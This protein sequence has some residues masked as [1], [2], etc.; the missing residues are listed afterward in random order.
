MRLSS[1]SVV[2]YRSITTAH[3]IQMNNL[4]V[5]VGKNNEGKS[6]ILRALNLAMS[7]MQ[8]FAENPRILNMNLSAIKSR[9]S[10]ER[11]YP[12]SLQDRKPNGYSSVDFTFDLTESELQSIRS[13][14]G[15]RLNSSLPVRV[16]INGRGAKIDIPKRGTPAFANIEKKL[17]I[18]EFVCQKIDIKFIPAIRTEDDSL[19]VIT[20]LIENELSALESSPEYTAAISTI[21]DLQQRV[22][23][24]IASQ[25]VHP[26]R[27]FLP[28]VRDIQIRI[29]REQRRVALRRNI[30]VVVD[31]GTPTPIQL[32]G[33][34]IKSLTAIAMLNIANEPGIVSVIAIEEPES[35]LHPE[36]TR[37]L[38]QTISSLSSSHQV[39]ITTHSPL[40]VNRA[41]LRDNIIVNNGKATPVKRIKEIREVLGTHVCD[42]LINAEYILLVEGESD[43]VALDKLLPSM[44]DRIKRA[45]QNGTLVIDYI[46]GAGNLPYKLTF[47][48]SI[49]CNYYVLLDNDDAGRQAY[50]AATA[51]GLLSARNTT[52]TMCN[53]SPNAELEDCY[54]SVAYEQAILREF[55]VNIRAQEFSTNKKWSER[56]AN[57]FRSQ[58][59]LWNEAVEKHVKAVVATAI[60]DEHTQALNPHKRASID[61]LANALIGIMP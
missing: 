47:Y 38:F 25:I 23:D 13:L 35:H 54:Q 45:L 56:V 7:I 46:G 17:K 8:L 55:G 4:T 41:S 11:D 18:I 61:A 58:G 1:F 16:L 21:V 30:E 27:E 31:D 32:K 34:G 29:Q 24:R 26:L 43:K 60:I 52:F 51:Q 53:G 36:S 19:R 48:R 50:Q 59:K 42:N 39:I 9:Y 40:F 20:S 14:T 2:N 22:L 3:K 44:S 28:P 10:W 49:Q 33:D 6:N 15:I 57:C 5:L 37:Q 12:L